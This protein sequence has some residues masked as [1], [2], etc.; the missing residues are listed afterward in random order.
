MNNISYRSTFSLLN[1]DRVELDKS[2]NYKNVIS[3]FY[4]LYLIEDGEAILYNP[5]ETI[6]LEKGYLYLVPSFTYFNTHCDGYLEQYYLHF[7]EEAQNGRSLFAANRNLLK[8]KANEIDMENFRRIIKL[9]PN[10]GLQRSHDPKAYEKLPVL[11]SNAEMN[12]VMQLSAYTETQGI[13]LQLLSRFL[14]P[15][16]FKP[17][18]NNIIHSKVLDAINYIQTNLQVNITVAELA[19]RANQSADHFSRLFIESTGERPL[20]YIRHKKIEQAQVLLSTTDRSLSEIAIDTG[21][22]SLSYFSK[23]FKQITGLSPSNYKQNNSM[24]I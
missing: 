20:V 8:T 13:L 4:R 3:T 14:T 5:T 12:N 21:F 15:E 10:R 1:T 16:C 17:D 22:D 23:M 11:Q 7:V 18:Q 2:W 6:T 19:E 24:M 9:N